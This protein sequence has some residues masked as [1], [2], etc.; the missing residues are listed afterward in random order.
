MITATR[1]DLYQ[2]QLHIGQHVHCIL[3]GG[4]DGI[5]TAI[6]G[7]QDPASI[8]SFGGAIVTGGRATVTVAF[9]TYISAGIPESIV[10]GVQWRISEEIAEPAEIEAAI[11]K[12]AAATAEA[13]REEQ[14]KTDTRAQRRAA[15]PG[16][17]PHLTPLTK[18]GSSRAVGAKNLRKELSSTFPGVSFKV[19]SKSYSGGCSISVSWTDGPTSEQV[20]P[21][22]NRYEYGSFDGM[23]DSYD[24]NRENIWPDVFGGAKYVHVSR[25]VSVALTISAAKAVLHL[26]LMPEQFDRWGQPLV[27]PCTQQEIYRAAW[28]TE[29]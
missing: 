2:G 8:R 15:L 23:T 5:I 25:H 3:Y 4:R 22:A 16:E 12:A 11:T 28:A 18:S 26:D 7:Q 20:K 24:Y 27:D 13:R 10:R 6:A 1:G 19:T 9:E 14:R 17:H 29:G 21:I